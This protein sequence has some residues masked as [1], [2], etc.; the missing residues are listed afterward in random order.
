M[1]CHLLLADPVNP[2]SSA[3]V[4]FLQVR[5]LQTAP[6]GE[7]INVVFQPGRSDDLYASAKETSKLAYRIL[8]REGLV[9]TQ[10]VAQCQVTMAP[11]NVLGRSSDLAFALAILMAGYP[12]SK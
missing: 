4:V 7:D 5:L 9:R 11:L 10:L 6:G 12:A 2:S 3:K 8:F 1:S